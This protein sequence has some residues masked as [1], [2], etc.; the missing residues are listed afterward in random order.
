MVD[1]PPARGRVSLTWKELG[2]FLVLALPPFWGAALAAGQGAPDQPVEEELPVRTAPALEERIETRLVLVPVV[3]TDR[4]RQ[5]V[6]GL[7]RDDFDLRVD[8]KAVPIQTFDP[9]PPAPIAPAASPP[10]P[11][12]GLSPPQA[13]H[14]PAAAQPVPAHVALAIDL[15]QTRLPHMTMAIHM[16]RTVL[17]KAWPAQVQTALFVLTHG[18]MRTEVP[19]TQSAENLAQGLSRLDRQ[20]A[21]RDSWIMGE[22]GRMAEVNAIYDPARSHPAETAVKGYSAEQSLRVRKVLAALDS[23][24]GI[25]SRFPGRKSVVFL[26]DGIR[27]QAGLNYANGHSDLERATSSLRPEFQETARRFQRAGVSLSPVSLVGLY[28]TSTDFD[29]AT[30]GAIDQ[31]R[32]AN[33]TAIHR[34]NARDPNALGELLGSLDSL[35]R[36]TGGRPPVALNNFEEELTLAHR[37][38]LDSYKLGFRPPSGGPPGT[39]H[40]IRVRVHRPPLAVSA[41]K[42]YVDGS[43]RLEPDRMLRSAEAFPQEFQDLPIRISTYLLPVHRTG[44]EIHVQVSLPALS[45]AWEA[46]AAGRR[47]GKITL[48]GL[49]RGSNGTSSELFHSSYAPEVPSRPATQQLI[50]Q[51]AVSTTLPEDADL[52]VVTQDDLG[53][54]LGSA[55]APLDLFPSLASSPRLSKPVIIAPASQVHLFTPSGDPLLG[56][57]QGAQLFLPIGLPITGPGPVIITARVVGLPQGGTV[58]FC[59]ARADE[60][61]VE[62]GLRPPQ[63]AN[64]QRQDPGN[65]LAWVSVTAEAARKIT[66]LGVQVMDAQ[67]KVV[68]RVEP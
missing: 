30:S 23:L 28:Q 53:G 33:D 58:Q 45:L 27:E 65:W 24:L 55:V 68:A 47:Q 25:M 29:A 61:C 4:D 32:G 35:A 19:F 48:A 2:L 42:E 6:H 5:P 57:R 15:Y 56:V 1:W 54:E 46:P 17:K 37:Q 3:V 59:F 31:D 50:F 13:A 11:A 67:G 41:R 8:G 20:T 10:A 34:G 18:R 40:S 63:S 7:S 22:A 49:L 36:A 9:P 16:V 43:G 12:A 26:T 62:A 44:V 39:V 14:E 60:S 64:S 52:V 51:E 21:L 66:M 38:V